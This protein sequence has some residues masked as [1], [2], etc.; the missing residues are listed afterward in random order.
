MNSAYSEKSSRGMDSV[1]LSAAKD[2]GREWRTLLFGGQIL[3][4]RL[5]MT[6]SARIYYNRYKAQMLVAPQKL[7]MSEV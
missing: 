5:R 2:L 3:R 4:L 1:I 6:S 7:D